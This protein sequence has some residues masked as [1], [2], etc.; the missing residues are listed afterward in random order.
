M[1]KVIP[2]C[3]VGT[4]WLHFECGPQFDQ[5]VP[6]ENMGEKIL[7]VQTFAT[8]IYPA[9]TWWVHF[10]CGPKCDP[11][12]SGCEIG[13]EILNVIRFLTMMSPVSNMLITIKMYPPK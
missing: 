11:N 3:P 12:V 8:S 10:E 9:K 4:C 6:I 1:Q 7:N 13:E 2:M 5:N